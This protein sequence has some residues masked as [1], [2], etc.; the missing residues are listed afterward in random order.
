MFYRDLGKYTLCLSVN[1][2]LCSND[3]SAFNLK[4]RIHCAR[5]DPGFPVP[6]C[7]PPGRALSGENMYENER[8][9]SPW[10]GDPPRFANIVV[11]KDQQKIPKA[12]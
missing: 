3:S 11:T 2:L 10:G 4:F 1:K 6:G 9:G 7:R 8:I 12:Q 5:M